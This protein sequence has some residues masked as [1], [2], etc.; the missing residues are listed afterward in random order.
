MSIKTRLLLLLTSVIT[1]FSLI[2]IFFW[3]IDQGRMERL[4]DSKKKEKELLLDRSIALIQKSLEMFVYDYSYWDEML[5]FTK[6]PDPVWAYVNIDMVMPTFDAQA[7][8]IFNKDRQLVFSTQNAE[9]TTLLNFPLSDRALSV[10]QGQRYF[11]HFFVWNGDQLVEVYGAPLQPS[12][13]NKRITEPQGS[14]FAGRLWN[15]KFIEQLEE[16]NNTIIRIDRNLADSAEIRMETIH[17]HRTLYGWDSAAVAAVHNEF[18][19]QV[20]AEVNRLSQYQVG[21]LALFGLSFII[22]IIVF[23]QR[24][25]VSPMNQFSLVLKNENTADLK[26]VQKQSLELRQLA[27]LIE[28]FFRQRDELV[29]E[30]HTR[31][32]AEQ[33][34]RSLFDFAHDAIMV[35]DPLKMTVQRVN[36]AW[37]K[38]YGY[39]PE[40]M[41]GFLLAIIWP[42]PAMI[43]RLIEDVRRYGSAARF[44]AHHLNHERKE[45][46]AE[47]NARIIQYRSEEALL[48]VCRDM[49][50]MRM[51]ESLQ[52][53]HNILMR[54]RNLVLV[55]NAQGHIVY[56]NH[57]VKEMLGFEPHE[58]LGDGWWKLTRD[59]QNG[60]MEK[61]S[62]RK[63]AADRSELITVPYER[64]LK[65]RWGKRRCIIWS[66]SPAPGNLLIGVGY[67]ITDRI[68]A[69]RALEAS[70]Q[71]YRFMFDHIP[72]PMII[73]QIGKY[74]VIA[75]NL[76]ARKLF[77]IAETET[78]MALIG[79]WLEQTVWD[80]AAGTPEITARPFRRHDGTLVE[81]DMQS[82]DFELAGQWY[83]L[84]IL[85]DRTAKEQYEQADLRFKEHKSRLSGVIG[86]LEDERRRMASELHDG[87]GQI[88][89]A[90]KRMLESL[91]D[92]STENTSHPERLSMVMKMLDSAMAE[93]K[94][95]AFN[96]LPRALED[97]GLFNAVENLLNQVFAGSG[98]KVSFQIHDM[99]PRMTYPMEL[100]LYRIVQEAVNNIIKH[101]RAGE[102]S[103]QFV[104]HESVVILTVEDNGKGFDPNQPSIGMGL[105]GMKDRVAYLDGILHIDSMLDK[106]TS[107]VIEIPKPEVL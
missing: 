18:H 8:W 106:G 107:L 86:A 32:Q 70:E 76:S 94:T 28:S 41:G 80:I 13:D 75:V 30:C 92:E 19:S 11:S 102:V 6:N 27:E 57:A 96:L 47:I 51:I 9:D 77:G 16:I 35:V 26:N 10:I 46:V 87:L 59:D 74:A 33:D 101:A 100:A 103:V 34:Y 97:Y 93:T 62:I 88:L 54:V 21:L 90:A 49:T 72:F 91:T 29:K 7:V 55:S 89:S 60:L 105:R 71:R 50:E 2:F 48:C 42:H 12:D 38:L 63:A 20:I 3:K 99:P 52:L 17:F 68:Q 5:Y 45:I 36:E 84:A 37:I 79:D 98:V 65:D 61:E 85:T 22:T 95:I 40:E 25:V 14:F 43:R 44:E 58:V 1:C 69:Q 39:R 82:N 64:W 53:S 31:K 83:R 81:I 23:I 66:D 73:Y 56:A 4:I 104:G 67:E 78:N 24:W 15:E